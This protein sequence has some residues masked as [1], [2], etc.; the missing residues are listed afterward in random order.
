MPETDTRG[1]DYH[2]TAG[3]TPS[4]RRLIVVGVIFNRAGEVLLSKM[5]PNRGVFPGQWGLP[6]GGVE[7]G[8]I[9]EDALHREIQEE[10]GLEIEILTPVLFKDGTYSKLLKDG[11][12][13]T[14][15]MVFLIYRCQAV[16]E[17][18]ILD[19]EFSDFAWVAPDNLSS[20]DLNLETLDTFRR[21]GFL[22]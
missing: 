10:L 14:I 7:E 16:H 17:N 5:P 15:Y 20:F 19:P 21:M 8:E 22:K 3:E 6:G 9:I 13:K 4:L 11:S 18:V 1:Q 12:R 2:A